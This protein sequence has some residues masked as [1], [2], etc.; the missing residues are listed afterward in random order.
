MALAALFLKFQIAQSTFKLLKINL[1]S[2]NIEEELTFDTNFLGT[3]ADNYVYLFFLNNQQQVREFSSLGFVDSSS[4]DFN[5]YIIDGFRLAQIYGDEMEV[6]INYTQP[7]LF[8][9]A[10][11]TVSLSTAQIVK[12][13]NTYLF[14]AK[15][16][17]EAQIDGAIVFTSFETDIAS[18]TVI[19]AFRKIMANQDDTGGLAFGTFDGDIS[20]VYE[21]NDVPFQIIK[22]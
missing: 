6:F 1:E 21:F 11:G 20:D 12:G 5:A 19:Y 16:A 15:A 17:I 7:S 13:D 4:L 8:T 14:N 9:G 18:N 2:Q 3:I 22:N 10:P